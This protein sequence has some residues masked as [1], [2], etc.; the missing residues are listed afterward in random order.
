MLQVRLWQL[1][2]HN[3]PRTGFTLLGSEF[4]DHRVSGC[5]PSRS[6]RALQDKAT[7]RWGSGFPR[8]GVTA[9]TEL[10]TEQPLPWPES[11]GVFGMLSWAQSP[12]L[13]HSLCPSSCPSPPASLQHPSP[14]TGMSLT[15]LQLVIVTT[16]S[17]SWHHPSQGREEL[18]GYLCALPRLHFPTTRLPSSARKLSF[19]NTY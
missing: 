2:S 11:N 17:Q 10:C 13:Q 7:P 14:G 4:P 9:G 6:C 18:W 15:S 19:P 1:W 3:H 8:R 12:P 16:C 5:H